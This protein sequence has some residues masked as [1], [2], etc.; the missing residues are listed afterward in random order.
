ME[1]HRY[2]TDLFFHLANTID[3]LKTNLKMSPT[4]TSSDCGITL[5]DGG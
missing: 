3:V 4:M 5:T 2:E 1:W